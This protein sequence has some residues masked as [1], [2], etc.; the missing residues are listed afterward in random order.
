MEI[1]EK[2]LLC[3]RRQYLLVPGNIDC[4]FTG[5]THSITGKYTLYSHADLPFCMARKAKTTLYL[6]GDLFD[7]RA[8]SK[9]NKAI[10]HDLVILD[11]Q[12]LIEEVG[13]Y[14]GRFVIL[15]VKNSRI[16]LLH[17]AMATR[18][19]YYANQHYELWI[20]SQPHLLAKVMGIKHTVDKAKVLFYKS[21]V[22]HQLHN[23]SIGNTTCYDEIFQVM[24]NHFLNVSSFKIKRY[25][26]N[27]TIKYQPVGEVVEQCAEMINGFMNSIANRYNVML[28]VTAGKDSRMLLAG[29]YNCKEK[30]FYYVNKEKG[31]NPESAD[32]KM[33][34]KLFKQLGLDFHILDPYI[35]IDNDFKSVYFSNNP[36]ASKKYLPHIF[37]YYKNYADRINL[38]GNIASAGYEL[39]NYKEMKIS[40]ESLAHL[41]NVGM[42][43]FAVEYYDQWL[44]NCKDICALSNLTLLHLFYWEERMGNWGSQVQMDKDIAQED[45]NPFNSR[46][47]VETFLSVPGKYLERP[48][49]LLQRKIINHLW[50]E[51]LHVPINPGKLKTKLKILKLFGA[52][53]IMQRLKYKIILRRKRI[54]A[55][56]FVINES[57]LFS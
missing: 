37:N 38:P 57:Q 46:H 21:E 5:Q 14:S 29:S 3:Y 39:Y 54:K 45:I 24:P 34:L 11:F 55:M 15:Y 56:N 47:L 27:K 36:Y 25:W 43:K 31:L 52:L 1:G 48:D 33:P 16:L 4:P 19:I 51:L 7:Y 49:F 23:A 50:P 40:A 35:E 6:L 32:L 8:P 18:K 12:Q 13:H 17:D 44:N 26:P 42:Y 2:N 10:L 22:F 53:D 9:D 30:I 28:P 41:N 20:A